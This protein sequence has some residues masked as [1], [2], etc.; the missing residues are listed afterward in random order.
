MKTKAFDKTD[1]RSRYQEA[2]RRYQEIEY[3]SAYK[4]FGWIDTNFPK[5]DTSNGITRAIINFLI[6]SGHDAN[7]MTS[8]GRIAP[9]LERQASGTLLTVKKFIPSGTRKGTADIHAII[10]GRHVSIEIKIGRDK[11][12]EAQLK[13]QARVTRAGG[14]YVVIKTIE[15]FF[16][17]YDM[18]IK[19]WLP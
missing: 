19:I 1:W 8:A 4:D 18:N 13:E 5:V 12:S 7:R 15:E 2:H 16:A 9:G 6:W 3:P 14:I 17:W 10:N 11:Q